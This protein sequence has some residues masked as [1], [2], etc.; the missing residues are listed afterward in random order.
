M[1][2][3]IPMEYYT[4]RGCEVPSNSYC[5][6]V[7]FDPFDPDEVEIVKLASEWDRH[8]AMEK[9]ERENARLRSRVAELEGEWE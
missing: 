5:A 1:Y 9:L 8:Y 6:G 3:D 7:D 2:G 4:E